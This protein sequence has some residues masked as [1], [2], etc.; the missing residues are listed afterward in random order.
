[1]NVYKQ[2]K[3]VKKTSVTRLLIATF[4]AIRSYEAIPFLM[5]TYGFLTDITSCVYLSHSC[6]HVW[7]SGHLS[8]F[9]LVLSTVIF[10]LFPLKGNVLQL[11]EICYTLSPLPHPSPLL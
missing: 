10:V 1:M 2:D 11:S 7:I 8:S 4:L 6:C 9:N 3:S 5:Y